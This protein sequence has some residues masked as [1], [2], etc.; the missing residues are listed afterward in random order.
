MEQIQKEV[1][2]SKAE[3]KIEKIKAVEQQEAELLKAWKSVSDKDL[4]QSDC[5]FECDHY[6]KMVAEG[7]ST[8]CLIQGSGGL[9]KS[10]RAITILNNLDVDY[11][12]VDSYSTP[13]ALYVFM[14]ENKDKILLFDDVAGMMNERRGLAYLKAALWEC[15]GKRMVNNLTQKP[16]KDQ[17]DEPVPNHFEFT[18]GVIILTNKLNDRNAHTKAVLTRINSVN[19]EIPFE[20]RKRI[21]EEIAKKP[22]KDLAEEE[23]QEVVTLIEQNFSLDLDELNL[24]T[25]FKLYHFREYSKNNNLGELWKRLALKLFKKDERLALVETLEKRVDLKGHQKIKEFQKILGEDVSKSTYYRLR[26]QL[27]LRK[28]GTN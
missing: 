18:G 27:Q 8:G 4:T 13:A 3:E 2:K 23:R 22:Y 1:K 9:G 19:L 12:Y 15:N 24:R 26:E 14:Y 11:A 21:I 28:D 5:Y 16:L 7:V 17:Y 6:V 10:Y 20:E 25:L